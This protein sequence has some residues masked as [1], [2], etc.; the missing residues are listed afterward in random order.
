[1][2]LNYKIKL[3]NVVEKKLAKER[4]LTKAQLGREAFVAEVWKWKT[5]Y[6]NRIVTQLKR[7]GSSLDWERECFTMDEVLT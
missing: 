3:K 2:K 7:L 4:R 6:G 1:L 5:E